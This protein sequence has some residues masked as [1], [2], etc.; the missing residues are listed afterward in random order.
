[1]QE[2]KCIY[3]YTHQI[4][5]KFTSS[6]IYYTVNHYESFTGLFSPHSLTCLKFPISVFWLSYC[7]F[8]IIILL[9]LAHCLGIGNSWTQL[10][11][12]YVWKMTSTLV[13][14][15]KTQKVG[16]LCF[17]LFLL[18]FSSSKKPTPLGRH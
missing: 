7:S 11:F 13:S 9:F 10:R 14:L 6:S 15:K 2:H 3:I 8:S 5:L 16:K 4:S 1:M 18:V 12:L 17:H